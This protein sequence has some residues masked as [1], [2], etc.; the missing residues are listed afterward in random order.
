MFSFVRLEKADPVLGVEMSSTGEVAAI[1]DDFPDALIKA[2]E[3]TEMNIPILGGN[4]LISVGGDRLK[5][6]IVPLARKLTQLGFA[7]FATEDTA[8]VLKENHVYAVKLHKVQEPDKM[9]NIKDALESGNIDM[10]INIPLADTKQE[11]FKS[12][13]EADYEIRRLAVDFNVPVIV[14]LQLTK[15]IIDAIE[16][17][18]LKDIE[19]KSLNEYHQTLEDIYW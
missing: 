8:A 3:A 6:K 1:G 17:V 10:V 13:L 5:Q 4:I 19:I 9:P 2:L 16:R 15:A 14:D 7:L 18:R 11:K 12:I